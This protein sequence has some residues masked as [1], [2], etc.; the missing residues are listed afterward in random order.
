MQR[1][2][3]QAALTLPRLGQPNSRPTQIFQS[4]EET[5]PAAGTMETLPP[6][7]AEAADYCPCHA[8]LIRGLNYPFHHNLKHDPEEC[9]CCP[10]C[11][12]KGVKAECEAL[13]NAYWCSP[14]CEHDGMRHKWGARYFPPKPN[15][16]S[17]Y[18]PTSSHWSGHFRH[19]GCMCCLG[20]CAFCWDKRKR[21]ILSI[22]RMATIEAEREADTRRGRGGHGHGAQGPL[23][24]KSAPSTMRRD[25]WTAGPGLPTP[26]PPAMA[27]QPP[28]G[29]VNYNFRAACASSAER[30]CATEAEFA[31]QEEA[32]RA[33]DADASRQNRRVN[34]EYWATRE[35]PKRRPS[36]LPSPLISVE[37]SGSWKDDLRGH[38]LTIQHHGM[39][40]KVVDRRGHTIML[41]TNNYSDLLSGNVEPYYLESFE[42]EQDFISQSLPLTVT[43]EGVQHMGALATAVHNLRTRTAQMHENRNGLNGPLEVAENEIRMRSAEEMQK[44]VQDDSKV[45]EFR[46]LAPNIA[47]A[48]RGTLP[49]NEKTLR[50]GAAEP[51]AGEFT[52]WDRDVTILPIAFKATFGDIHLHRRLGG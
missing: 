14:R 43:V 29:P 16:I 44:V 49:F 30:A 38:I 22:A 39:T 36:S 21:K 9:Y 2:Q 3:A 18:Q 25:P 28:P 46:V 19:H 20:M 4:M 17:G 5:D 41:E 6:G 42:D 35:E 13:E 1:S 37:K 15:E 27:K 11:L 47:A 31:A 45:L 24:V 8:G 32:E 40:P 7:A 50:S 48:M 26:P 51:H 10:F 23:Q 12:A 34:A 52:C 33:A